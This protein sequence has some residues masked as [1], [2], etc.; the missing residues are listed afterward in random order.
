MIYPLILVVL[1]VLEL[2]FVCVVSLVESY[3]V[4]LV[5]CP[6]SCVVCLSVG[7][8]MFAFGSRQQIIHVSILN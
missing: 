7:L 4:G 3:V 8:L 1:V 6:L 2:A 5:F